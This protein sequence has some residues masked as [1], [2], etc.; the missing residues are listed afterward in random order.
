M[1]TVK[2]GDVV[3]IH[4]TGALDDGTVFDSSEGRDPL[5]FKVGEGRVIPGFEKGVMGMAVGENKKIHIPS[6]EA[7]GDYKEEMKLTAPRQNF[8]KDVEIQT[9]MQFQL[10][11]DNGQ[12]ILA[13]VI[14]FTDTDV[15]LDA[16][17]PLA[18]KNL[19]FDLKLEVIE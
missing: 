6:E 1:S 13:S 5:E 12:V 11:A 2:D 19:N 15:H 8:P 10:Q 17:H 18:G 3:K 9:G 4:Y 16:N 7:Y 14:G